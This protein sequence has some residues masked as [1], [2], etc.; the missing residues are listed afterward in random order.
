MYL[1]EVGCGV[2][3]GLSWL[4]AETGDGQL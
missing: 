4:K 3:V 1:Q 2:C